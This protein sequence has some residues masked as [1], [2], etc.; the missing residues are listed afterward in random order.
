MRAFFNFLRSLFLRRRAKHQV[1]A[2]RLLLGL[3][4]RA[5]IV[6]GAV[7][8]KPAMA[9]SGG[10]V[11]QGAASI[12]PEGN[13]TTIN[14]SSDRA[15]ITWKD[16]NIAPNEAVQFIQPNANSATLNQ[17]IGNMGPT[18]IQGMLNAN[19]R[20]FI[21][22][23]NGVIFGRGAQVNVGGLVA[24][25]LSMS[26]DSFMSGANALGA[27][28]NGLVTGMVN[29]EAGAQITAKTFVALLS[30][31]TVNNAG[32]IHAGMD[33]NSSERG[34]AMVAAD[35]ATIQLGNFKVTVNKPAMDAL[36]ANSGDL[37]LG[38]SLGDG[39]IQLNAAGRN[40]LMRTLL[41]NSGK[42]Q[43]HSQGAGSSVSLESGGG[44]SHV[45]EI[46]AAA[47]KVSL[48]G[49]E[50]ALDGN[51][52]VGTENTTTP[53]L[54]NIGSQATQNVTQ[55][56][57]SVISANSKV[58][59][60]IQIAAQRVLALSGA[61]FAPS[62][63]ISLR[64]TILDTGL[65]EPVA[66]TIHQVGVEAWTKLPLKTSDGRVVYYGVDGHVYAEDGQRLDGTTHLYDELNKDVGSVADIDSNGQKKDNGTFFDTSTTKIKKIRVSGAASGMRIINGKAVPHTWLVWSPRAKKFYWFDFDSHSEVLGPELQAGEVFAL[67]GGQLIRAEKGVNGE[68]SFVR[69]DGRMQGAVFG[70]VFDAALGIQGQELKLRSGV[71]LT[72]RFGEL[73]VGD[74]GVIRR[75]E[76]SYDLAGSNSS[77]GLG[78]DLSVKEHNGEFT[79]VFGKNKNLEFGLDG[80]R[81]V[82]VDRKTG[83]SVLSSFD[84]VLDG[85]TDPA[86]RRV[87][88]DAKGKVWAFNSGENKFDSV[89]H[90]VQAASDAKPN[91]HGLLEA[92]ADGTLKTFADSAGHRFAYRIDAWGIKRLMSVNSDGSVVD[93]VSSKAV[94]TIDVGGTAVKVRATDAR[95]ISVAD[96][97]HR[98]EGEQLFEV[99][100]GSGNP[101]GQFV[102]GDGKSVAKEKIVEHKRANF[103]PFQDG[104]G[105]L[106]KP[107]SILRGDDGKE[108]ARV[109]KWRA[110]GAKEATTIMVDKDGKLFDGETAHS[111]HKVVDV[112]GLGVTVVNGDNKIVLPGDGKEPGDWGKFKEAGYAIAE[113][114]QGFVATKDN[115]VY[116]PNSQQE[117]KSVGKL[118]EVVNAE[119][120]LLPGKFEGRGIAGDGLSIN[121]II[122]SDGGELLRRSASGYE[123]MGVHIVEDPQYGRLFVT[124]KGHLAEISS[125]NQVTETSLSIQRLGGIT[126]VMDA[127]KQAFLPRILNTEAFFSSFRH[128]MILGWEPTGYAAKS[129]VVNGV[130][131]EMLVDAS[132]NVGMISFQGRL[133]VAVNENFE[134]GFRVGLTKLE[135]KPLVLGMKPGQLVSEDGN[136]FLMGADGKISRTDYSV[137]PTALWGGVIQKDGVV[138]RQTPS[139]EFAPTK[140]QLVDV[141]G[142]KKVLVGE[143][144]T[145]VLG[146]DLQPTGDRVVSGHYLL[147]ADKKYKALDSVAGE[148]VFLDSQG[149]VVDA[150]GQAIATDLIDLNTGLI[151]GKDGKPKAIDVQVKDSK[152]P[153]YVKFDRVNKKLVFVDADG[154]QVSGALVDHENNEIHSETGNRTGNRYVDV[155]GHNSTPHNVL[156]DAQGMQ[157][158]LQTRTR[159]GLRV[160]SADNRLEMVGADHHV[161]QWDSALQKFKSTNDAV[162]AGQYL[163]HEPAYV[164][165]Q[166]RPVYRDKS[167][168]LVIPTEGVAPTVQPVTGDGLV[169]AKTRLILGADLKP[170]AHGDLVTREGGPVYL[171]VEKGAQG[172]L[173]RVPADVAGN[174]LPVN[175]VVSKETYQALESAIAQADKAGQKGLADALR[176]D[177]GRGVYHTKEEVASALASLNAVNALQRDVDSSLASMEGLE[178]SLK[179]TAGL[180][181]RLDRFAKD[182]DFAQ[183]QSVLAEQK[184]V[185]TL[186]NAEKQEAIRARMNGKDYASEQEARA[187]LALQQAAQ[188]LLD[189]QREKDPGAKIVE[190]GKK[191]VVLDG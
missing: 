11:V 106:A 164:T 103:D 77:L 21:V 173:V 101:T 27:S 56:V 24:S 62:G 46:N 175:G 119:R 33:A 36:V 105:T 144:G 163:R 190:I 51:V 120:R 183:V 158:D 122:V 76:G 141:G 83:Q 131:R 32:S 124:S 15:V 16:F 156:I 123:P 170:K 28:A 35:A 5:A 132:G 104:L 70:A 115:V 114:T 111:D 127:Q 89:D 9:V 66:K 142:D 129:I 140:F 121:K 12:K 165:A 55:G 30:A 22:D 174:A 43:N 134:Q 37:V 116:E 153:V 128:H 85:V 88:A 177:K 152:T 72:V 29:V 14:Q 135:L 65:L 176:A 96:D 61:L 75:S 57:Q 31:S 68:F 73:K 146:D 159:T 82:V 172:L 138:Y 102:S 59:A 186:I 150:Q 54:I 26:P 125:E 39:S 110:L 167:G 13:Q 147:H 148:G 109:V 2:S 6:V 63:Q 53:S 79:I 143:N 155:S 187:D 169:D 184:K 133:G 60:Q 98:Q 162:V 117:M 157:L 118:L 1:G 95:A 78:L 180:E 185:Q 107:V 139:G 189:K 67:G 10:D 4:S 42:I 84:H 161:W 50:I 149:R 17:V 99:L 151:L 181:S 34:I 3:L 69:A 44:L 112:L 47:G 18:T 81:V 86:G 80:D 182:K 71:A 113:T 168:H 64:A 126:V 7:A 91:E 108:I 178:T 19:G 179:Q 45:G 20:I 93:A 166:E 145:D 100:D 49:K 154:K 40:A 97:T 74:A 130:A 41:S 191:P 188:A 94:M 137:T 171:K 90:L 136:L 8:V 92:N 58:D 160:V 48:D 25:S 52:T 23:P 87:F 38:E